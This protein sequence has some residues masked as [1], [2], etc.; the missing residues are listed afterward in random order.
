MKSF[1]KYILVIM[2]LLLG[3]VS[4]NAMQIFVKTLTGK[5][6][7]LE[8]EPTDS[9]I[10]V[11]QKIFV[12]EDIPV[13]NQRLIFAGKQLEDGRTLQDYSIQNHSTLHLVL[14]LGPVLQSD[15][16]WKCTMPNGDRA[17][18]ITWKEEAGLAW[19][20]GEDSVRVIEDAVIGYLGFEDSVAF[21]EIVNPNNC[22]VYYGSSNEAVATINPYTGAIVFVS[23]G[24]TTIY[25]VHYT[26][27][28][29]NSYHYDSVY[30][31]LTVNNP[32]LL[33]LVAEGNGTVEFSTASLPDGVL[34]DNSYSGADSRY[35]VY[36]TA[37]ELHLVASPG[38]GYCLHKWNDEAPLY[39]LAE[40][41]NKYVTVN[42]SM[43]IT[44]HFV[45]VHTLTLARDVD[46]GSLDFV[47]GSTPVQFDLTVNTPIPSQN[48]ISI[49][50]T[51]HNDEGFVLSGDNSMTASITS[52]TITG[53]TITFAYGSALL[54][55]IT[56]NPVVSASQMTVNGNQVT[57]SGLSTNS[58]TISSTY[59]DDVIEVEALTVHYGS[60]LPAGVLVKDLSNSLSKEY[61]A[62]HGT[63]VSVVAVPAN[64]YYFHY[65]DD[66]NPDNPTL[67]RNQMREG[68]VVNDNMTLTAHFGQT[69]VL[70]LATEGNGTVAFEA[71]RTIAS[72]PF[73]RD[74]PE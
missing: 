23:T 31:T 10:A 2:M 3:S 73:M 49:S 25:A 36:P 60:A 33:T 71:E 65:W 8:V 38:D 9:I 6:I 26:N 44:A 72:L 45:A 27:E 15:G 29:E 56:F 47:V 18:R 19:K 48:N 4:A 21:P 30:Y 63:E 69:P 28:D 32:Y 13:E 20:L 55:Q 14:R 62:M 74:L 70:T 51:S 24:T 7:T 17:L 53:V 66:D 41:N 52:G 37:G 16:S 1:G 50:G 39:S 58:F 34:V 59:G 61:Y 12:K 40:N 67:G 11:K 46:G 35:L 57:I 42:E 22:N 68:I 5:H 54:N 43:T 64:G